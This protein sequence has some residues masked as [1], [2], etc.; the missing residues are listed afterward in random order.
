MSDPSQH[1]FTKLKQLVRYLK[2]QRQWIQVFKLGDMSSEATVFSDSGWAGDKETRKSSSAFAGRHFFKAHRRKQKI[3]AR[4]SPE[5]ELCVG[6]LGASEAKGVQSIMC[7]L[8]FAMKP[9]LIFDAKA[10][11]HIIHGHGTGKLKLTDAA[12]LWLQD[13]VKSNRL[14]V[15]RVKCEDNLAD[16]G[17][18]A[19]SNK[20][21]RKHATSM[22]YFNAQGNLKSEDVM[23]LWVGK[24]G[25]SRSEQSRPAENVTGIN[26][27]PC[28]T[29]TAAAVA[30]V[31]EPLGVSGASGDGV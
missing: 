15:R 12:H 9:V 10:T 30:S 25:A 1:S 23:G 3:I 14:R 28:Q 18:K 6:A 5:A 31:A 11:E 27:W 22:G 17:T 4:S 7:D 19:L 29:A 13:E 20:I 16:I 8:G 2:G 21:I 26:W 24:L